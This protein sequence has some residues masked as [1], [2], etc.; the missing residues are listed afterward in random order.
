MD[1]VFHAHTQG[2]DENESASAPL[3][4]EG[5]AKVRGPCL[6]FDRHRERLGLR[7]LGD[8]VGEDLGFDGGV[9][10]IGDAL[11]HQL[12]GPLCDPSF[13]LRG[14]DYF[15]WWALRNHRDGVGIEVVPEFPLGDQHNIDQLLNL[16]VTRLGV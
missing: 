5:F 11:P 8:E 6:M 2:R 14:L 12:Q 16:G 15:F 7:P 4:C 3:L 9:G 10:S 13:C 1:H